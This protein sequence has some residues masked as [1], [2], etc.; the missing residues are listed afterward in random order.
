MGSEDGPTPPVGDEPG[1][2]VA[3]TSGAQPLLPYAQQEVTDEDVAEVVAALRSGWLTTG[4]RVE[5]FEEQF[6][7]RVD[8]THAIS[9][10]SGTAALH[11]C[12]FAAGLGPQDEAITSPMT[13][14]A[15]ANCV[16]YQGATPVLADVEADTLTLDS[17]AVADR[18][19]PR[20]RAVL[21][22]D[23][24]GHPCDLDAFAELAKRHGL[25]V[26]EDACHALGAEY[27]G[28]KVGGISSMTVFS[29]HPV[30][31]ITTGEG[32]MV[33]TDDE[34]LAARLR[35]FRN[36][37]IDRDSHARRSL[38]TWEYEVVHLGYNYRLSDLA[39]ALGSAQL[40]RLD[41][42]LARRREIAAL[43]GE[44]FSRYPEIMSPVCRGDVR[45]AWHLYPIRLRLESLTTDRGGVFAAL[46]EEGIG[47][48]VHYIPVH[49]HPYH[50][51]QLGWEPGSFP[52]AE[53][54]YDRLLS[55]PLFH[56]MTDDDVNR[57]IAAV[58]RVIARF[59]R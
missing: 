56:A 38:E 51:R 24:A 9:F 23:Y 16:L 13:F 30:K 33:T 5:R 8:A 43:Y 34:E 20:T 41:A 26:I 45:P 29:F 4:P 14:C 12:A 48:N 22:V 10:S 55:L 50:Q 36:H 11:G 25:V 31:H 21:P 53:D 19:G 57:V 49:Y 18:I 32:G 17:D 42:N 52:V 58:D 39:C 7:E 40:A 3:D 35:R 54:A 1:A 47:V 37:G 59:S 46:R 2:E 6:A 44:A 27:K 28:R 15:T